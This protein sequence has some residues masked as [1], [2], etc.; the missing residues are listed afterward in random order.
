MNKLTYLAPR[1]PAVGVL[2]CC[3][4]LMLVSVRCPPRLVADSVAPRLPAV[5]VLVC[6]SCVMLVSVR[7]PPSIGKQDWDSFRFRSV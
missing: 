4:C 7:C 6:G 2:V 1:L 5:G 3:S